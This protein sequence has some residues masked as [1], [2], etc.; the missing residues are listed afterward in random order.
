VPWRFAGAEVEYDRWSPALG[1]HNHEI[2]GGLLGHCDEHIAQW[3]AEG[4]VR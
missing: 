1:E 3:I 2:L 4:A